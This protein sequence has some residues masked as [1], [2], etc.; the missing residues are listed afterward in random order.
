MLG[1]SRVLTNRMQPNSGFPKLQCDS[2]RDY[3]NGILPS[4]S[5]VQ[6]TT[7]PYDTYVREG[8]PIGA[9]CNPGLDAIDCALYP[10]ETIYYY[11]LADGKGN[12]YFSETNE[13][14]EALKKQYIDNQ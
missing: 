13:Q 5:G 10:A 8:L 11:F 1:V 2:T 7:S 14:H 3:I 9:I 4:V 12:T 6:V